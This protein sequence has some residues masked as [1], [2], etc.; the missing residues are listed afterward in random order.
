MFEAPTWLKDVCPDTEMGEAVLR[1]DWA[2]TNLGPSG[3]W[4]IALRTAVGIC[5]TTAFPMLITWGD[6]LVCLYNDGYRTLLG[7]KHPDALGSPLAFVWSDV[8]EQIGPLVESVLASGRAVYD[9]DL[10]LLTDRH[11]FLEEAHFLVSY[12]P[13]FDDDGTIRGVLTTVSET[14]GQTVDRRR[15]EYSGQLAAALHGVDDLTEVCIRAVHVLERARPT[16]MSAEIFLDIDGELTPVISSRGPVSRGLSRA[17]L[18]EIERGSVIVVP[19]GD[20]TRPAERIVHPIGSADRIN[21]ILVI[22]PSPNLPFDAAYSGFVTLLANTIDAAMHVA[23][24]HAKEVGRH[25]RISDTL[26]EAMLEPADDVPTIAA[27]YVPASGRLSVGGDWYDVVELGDDRRGLVVGDCVGH[28]LDA[29]AAMAQMR[30]VA[31]SGLLDGR[32]PAAVL[33]SLDLF[34]ERTDHAANATAVVMVIDRSTG[35]MTWS[36]AGHIPPLVVGSD[37]SVW[38]EDGGS[39]PLG[40][41]FPAERTNATHQ[42]HEGELLVLCSDG[43][44]ERRGEGLEEGFRRLERAVRERFT[45]ELH[46]VADHVLRTLVPER[47]EDDVILVV[48]CIDF[49]DDDEAP[50]PA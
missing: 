11:G 18:R 30:S 50:E 21:G 45:S 4:P 42:L 35:A 44:V 26:Q 13:L 8:W 22:E 48:K 6:D 9:E 12:S 39:I 32:D 41:G 2:S 37:E 40:T 33:E 20:G 1:F 34:A 47:P 17:E 10:M 3:E 23:Y 49:V 27:R 5:I 31:R 36:R 14:T 24:R 15:M 29:A 19:D 28:G 25:R 46:E 38:L 16:V 43:L 7:D